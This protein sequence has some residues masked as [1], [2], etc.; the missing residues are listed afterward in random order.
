MATCSKCGGRGKISGQCSICKG[1]G[2]EDHWEHGIIRCRFCNGTGKDKECDQC[3]GT[4]VFFGK[5]P[6]CIGGLLNA[7]GICSFCGKQFA[8]TP[9]SSSGSSPKPVAQPT[10]PAKTPYPK[11]AGEVSEEQFY[12]YEKKAKQ[13]DA[14]SCFMM[15]NA[16]MFENYE[17]TE[18]WLNKA[19]SL[20]YK[21][22]KNLLKSVKKLWNKK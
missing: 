18:E 21:D 3:D 17:K 16:Y 5:C 19:I 22:A 13:G 10:P 7:N 20:G 14:Y 1:T 12:Q 2:K 8:I 11:N 9:S 4:G 15:G 6:D